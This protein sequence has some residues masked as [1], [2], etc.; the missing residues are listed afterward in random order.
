V[1]LGP[2]AGRGAAGGGLRCVEGIGELRG[3]GRRSPSGVTGIHVVSPR[4]SRLPYVHRARRL[5]PRD[6]T[7]RD[8]IRVTTVART[9]VD[10]SDVLTAEQLAN[11]IHE[12]AFR[13]RF[14]LAAT[15]Q[16]MQRANGR[17]NLHRL[18]AAHAAHAG[19]K[20]PALA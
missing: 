20:D 2:A 11:V 5:D 6:I 16:A 4:R 8:G 10:L 15:H 1:G 18:S 12:A 7:I 3:G 14:S 13:N 19:V 17:R 9:L